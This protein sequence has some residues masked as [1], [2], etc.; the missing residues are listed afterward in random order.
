MSMFPLPPPPPPFSEP[1]PERPAP[2]SPFFVDAEPGDRT[3]RIKDL[4]ERLDQVS[5]S[6]IDSIGETTRELAAAKR[7]MEAA[8]TTKFKIG[9]KP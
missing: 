9:R 7:R 2:A 8:P 1:A 3:Q 6:T 4:E 5:R